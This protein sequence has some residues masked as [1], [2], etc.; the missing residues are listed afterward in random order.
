MGNRTASTNVSIQVNQDH[1]TLQQS[2]G[3]ATATVPSDNVPRSTDVALTGPADNT[4]AIPS[5]AAGVCIVPPA[6]SVNPKII[7]GIAADTGVVIDP[8]NPSTLFFPQTSMNNFVIHSQV[9]ETV[10]VIWL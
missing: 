10:T 9:N 4:I 3:V 8:A 7:K 6:G 5:K 2:F 1:W